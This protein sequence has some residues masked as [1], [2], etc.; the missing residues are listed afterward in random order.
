MRKW[1]LLCAI[2]LVAIVLRIYGFRAPVAEHESLTQAYVV[3]YVRSG[4]VY[5][6]TAPPP[7]WDLVAL[8]SIATS[9]PLPAEDVARGM[10]IVL[11]LFVIAAIYIILLNETS[12]TGAFFGALAFAT[13]P[14]MVFYSRAYTQ[15]M[16]SIFLAISSMLVAYW[17]WKKKWLLLLVVCGLL[18][19]GGASIDFTV[20]AMYPAIA[21]LILR[22][23]THARWVRIVSILIIGIV[24]LLLNTPAISLFPLQLYNVLLDQLAVTILGGYLVFLLLFGIMY[25][26]KKSKLHIALAIGLVFSIFFDKRLV[27][28]MPVIALLLGLGSACFFHLK[29]MKQT[30]SKIAVISAIFILSAFLSYHHVRDWYTIDS[31]LMKHIEAIRTFV[32]ENEILSTDTDGNAVYLYGAQ[33]YGYPTINKEANY[34]LL[35]TDFPRD[36]TGTQVYRDEKVYIIRL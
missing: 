30:T 5:D 4:I 36:I 15:H 18:F 35:K 33:R 28:A 25:P 7:T 24:P 29:L 12:L 26:G 11:S 34:L 3:S 22:T 31:M 32:P 17:Y 9:L 14:F 6:R 23:R 27:S 1:I 19:I 16:H 10:T 13:L 21:Y 20:Y 2:L 8:R